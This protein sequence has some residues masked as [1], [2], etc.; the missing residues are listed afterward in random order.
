MYHSNLYLVGGLVAIFYFPI[1]SHILGTSSSQLTFIFFRDVVRDIPA[2]LEYQNSGSTPWESGRV[3]VHRHVDVGLGWCT[4]QV[5]QRHGWHGWHGAVDTSQMNWAIARL[6]CGNI[7]LI[8]TLVT[9][10]K[11]IKSKSKTSDSLL[12]YRY[13]ALVVLPNSLFV[14]IGLRDFA[15][16]FCVIVCLMRLVGGFIFSGCSPKSSSH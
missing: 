12:F 11:I 3:P 4:L 8:C 16:I 14:G 6:K 1:F 2:M 10:K 13:I 7:L 15:S 9:F 5:A